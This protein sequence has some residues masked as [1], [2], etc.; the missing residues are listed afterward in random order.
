MTPKSISIAFQTDHPLSAY[1]PM[2]AR[3]EQYGF[4]GVTVYND[5][6]YQPAWLPLLEIARNTRRVRIGPAAVNPFTCHPIN[7]AGNIALLDEASGGRAYLGLARGAWLD[8]VGLAP[9]RPITA[10]REAFECVRHLLAQSKEPYRGQVFQLAG[11]DALRWKIVRPDVPLLLGSWGPATIR[12]CAAQIDEIKI[13]GTANPAIVPA[14]R[15]AATAATRAAGRDDTTIGICAGAVTV[16]DRDGAAARALARRKAA[17]YL[18]VIAPLDQ[19][20]RIEPDLIQ[21]INAAAAAYDF[22]RAAG[23]ISD[24]LLDR[25]AFAGTPEHVAEQALALFHAGADRVEFGTP[26]GLS[27]E[28]GLRLLGE[29]VLPLLRQAGAIDDQ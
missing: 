2:G 16:V 12:A 6:L 28:T 22:D 10:L 4:H 29:E 18:P 13:G 27:E 3:C 9:E 14:I 20:L 23:Y 5:M 8:F 19:T 21:R 11:G 25:L 17:L 15:A 26:H 24:A 1:G 7:I